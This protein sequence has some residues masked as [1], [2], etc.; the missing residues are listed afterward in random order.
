MKAEPRATRRVRF[1]KFDFDGQLL[2]RGF[3]L[4]VWQV[5]CGKRRFAY[6]GRTGDS[7]SR[8]AA[9]PFSRVGSHLNLKAN[10]KANTLRRQIRNEKFNPLA[11]SFRFV[12]FGPLYGESK[13]AHYQRRDRMAGLEK[14]LADY[15][16]T[17]GFKVVGSHGKKARPLPPRLRSAV[18]RALGSSNE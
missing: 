18:D 10:A 4:Y 5:R 14:S 1:F 7:S 8:N 3:W 2:R 15:L 12:A 13:T 16:T 17:R 9:S 6:V 11:C